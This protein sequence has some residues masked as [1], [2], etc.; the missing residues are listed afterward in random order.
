MVFPESPII[1][2]K[3]Y[4]FKE[5]IV[6]NKII[7]IFKEGN[8]KKNMHHLNCILKFFTAIFIIYM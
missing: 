8:K 5:K 7:N 2:P 4:K 3:I 6:I 1:V